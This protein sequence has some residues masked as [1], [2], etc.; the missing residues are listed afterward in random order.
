M[1]T[2]RAA[3]VV[4]AL[5]LTGAWTGE[6]RLL[7]GPDEKVAPKISDARPF[8][9]DHPDWKSASILADLAT[10][11]DKDALAELDGAGLTY[12]PLMLGLPPLRPNAYRLLRQH[13]DWIRAMQGWE[14][15]L[16]MP[17]PEGVKSAYVALKERFWRSE[18]QLAR[19]ILHAHACGAPDVAAELA[20]LDADSPWIQAAQAHCGLKFT[21]QEA[22]KKLRAIEA[23]VADTARWLFLFSGPMVL[24]PELQR[25]Q[26]QGE[27][28][29]AWAR[30]N[31]GKLEG[32]RELEPMPRQWRNGGLQERIGAIAMDT[33]TPEQL[34]ALD[35][36]IFAATKD[37]FD[38]QASINAWAFSALA[39]ARDMTKADRQQMAGA[40]RHSRSAAAIPFALWCVN[41]GMPTEG[42]AFSLLAFHGAPDST[43]PQRLVLSLAAGTGDEKLLAL[44]GRAILA[45]A[46]DNID[47]YRNILRGL[48]RIAGFE[49]LRDAFQ[50]AL[51]ASG[52]KDLVA[53][54]GMVKDGKWEVLN[55][56]DRRPVNL[57]DS[58]QAKLLSVFCHPDEVTAHGGAEALLWLNK[59]VFLEGARRLVA[60]D[61]AYRKAVQLACGKAPAAMHPNIYQ[62]F[63]FRLRNLGPAVRAAYEARWKKHDA[64]GQ[65][66]LAAL[67]SAWS[68]G[69][70]TTVQAGPM[71][72]F[73][74][75]QSGPDALPQDLAKEL[76]DG[77]DKWGGAGHA[78][79]ARASFDRGDLAGYRAGLDAA[80]RVSPLD[81]DVY[82]QFTPRGEPYMS[83]SFANWET[84]ARNT[85]RLAMLH[86]YSNV[87]QA[88]MTLI[89]HRT[90][91]YGLCADAACNAGLTRA[92]YVYWG[93]DG[94]AMQT[95]RYFG[96]NYHW[97]AYARLGMASQGLLTQA[98]RNEMT[99]VFDVVSFSL[100]SYYFLDIA[101]A[102]GLLPNFA[103]LT[104][105][106]MAA[107]Y[108]MQDV[109]T[110]L[111]IARNLARTDAQTA[112][113]LV[114]RADDIGVSEYGR[115][116]GTQ[117]LCIACARLGKLDDVWE[118]YTEM[119]QG[120]VGVPKYLDNY[121]LAG[122]TSA[123]QHAVLPRII[124]AVEGYGPAVGDSE[125]AFYW[126]RA[127][128]AAGRHDKLADMST[129]NGTKAFHYRNFK[130]YTLL[131][132]E[133]RALLAAGNHAE[134]I[135]RTD[136]YLVAFF[137][138]TLGEYADAAIL[139]AI[140]V[141]LSGSKEPLI[142]A[143]VV[144]RITDGDRVLDYQV[145]ATL[146]GRRKGPLP[147]AGPAGYWHGTRWAER[148]PAFQGGGRATIA[149][150]SARDPFMRG[151]LAWLAGDDAAAIAKLKECVAA[152]QR[153]SHEYHVAEW[154]L[155][156]P[157]KPKEGK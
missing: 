121:L 93:E 36:E 46:P 81:F 33:L 70:C 47:S 27:V 147:E 110:L 146:A 105:G 44:A 9:G 60:A 85:W 80:L 16:V 40:A 157:L 42:M 48:Y 122:A 123:N 86:P 127:H 142:P 22:I 13:A 20:A 136:P 31:F 61:A 126:R 18:T 108:N 50:K 88:W 107:A 52:D 25:G 135:K 144:D 66:A 112:I 143:E 30:D 92:P 49:A 141:K 19:A 23:D 130:P 63:M 111:D 119:R 77:K 10:K 6:P 139:R 100:Q 32:I 21:G 104:Y 79:V 152:D 149:E 97:R 99:Q 87:S 39:E 35:K 140:A 34:E 90:G 24:G 131:F 59:A 102:F 3:L 62:Y 45:L 68:A 37:L 54:A 150:M 58:V 74:R 151:V 11:G 106:E 4:L 29:R 51:A 128:M 113:D 153:C 156:N 145:I 43:L 134:L 38:G 71:A 76:K 26:N 65:A 69:G 148:P 154:L 114:K 72:A 78:A 133:A 155:A 15:A 116:V 7:A 138:G 118:R 8:L 2:M 14:A 82:Y 84:V 56:R 57:S 96:R 41:N 89:A 120:D 132:H 129:G 67:E 137:E 83:N 117:T 91:A 109:S 17:D 28:E 125:F 94:Y 64:E 55:P 73:R 103:R 124:E 12:V 95:Y 75:W 53:L 115:F 101:N 1:G 5:T 98:Q